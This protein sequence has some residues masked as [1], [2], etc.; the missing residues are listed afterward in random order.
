MVLC[1]SR[2]MHLG[3]VSYAWLLP[4]LI[5]VSFLSTCWDYLGKRS[6]KAWKL[7]YTQV[8]WQE[9]LKLLITLDHLDPNLTLGTTAAEQRYSNHY[10]YRLLRDGG[11]QADCWVKTLLPM[12]LLMDHTFLP[13]HALRRKVGN[14]SVRTGEFLLPGKKGQTLRS[15]VQHY[16]TMLESEKS[17]DMTGTCIDSVEYWRKNLASM[18]PVFLAESPVLSLLDYE[19]MDPEAAS[20]YHLDGLHRL[21]AAGLEEFPYMPAYVAVNNTKSEFFQC[22][23]CSKSC[24]S[25]W[26]RA[27]GRLQCYEP[28]YSWILDLCFQFVGYSFPAKLR[29][30]EADLNGLV[31]GTDV[32]NSRSDVIAAALHA[33]LLQREQW[34][35]FVGFRF[36]QAG[37]AV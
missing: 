8:S 15:A 13:E 36:H 28:G 37:R 20:F 11:V 14:K 1:V 35:D 29:A 19:E 23:R 34:N 16:S 31:I 24:G 6:R 4:V 9:P 3:L 17:R 12:A 10:P 27:M 30:T 18:Q 32:Y 7:D 2:R 25:W 5:T 26:D 21:L 33:G 22:S